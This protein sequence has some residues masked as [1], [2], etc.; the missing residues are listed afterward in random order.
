MRW[1]HGA[2]GDRSWAETWVVPSSGMAL[3]RHRAVM[4]GGSLQ[5]WMTSSAHPRARCP[6]QQGPGFVSAGPGP[7]AM[8]GRSGTARVPGVQGAWGSWGETSRHVVLGES[9]REGPLAQGGD[10]H[11]QPPLEAKVRRGRSGHGVRAQSPWDQGPSAPVTSQA[12]AL[13][14][15]VTSRHGGGA[16]L[17]EGQGAPSASGACPSDGG[18]REGGREGGPVSRSPPPR[19]PRSLRG[20]RMAL[21]AEQGHGGGRPFRAARCLR[22]T[23]READVVTRGRRDGPR[24]RARLRR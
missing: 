12:K 22:T 15:G 3:T 10:P 9:H 13:K 8:A 24:G 1:F 19:P 5:V 7:L 2:E 4:G 17:E 16:S 21:S 23:S 6:P 11:T 20:G 18:A 14:R